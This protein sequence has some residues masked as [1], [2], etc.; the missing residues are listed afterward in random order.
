MEG[1]AVCSRFFVRRGKPAPTFTRELG[2]G[3]SC[4]FS[5]KPRGLGRCDWQERAW[6]RHLGQVPAQRVSDLS[7]WERAQGEYGLPSR[8]QSKVP[9]GCCQE[10]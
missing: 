10:G 9:G 3:A 6:C 7:G 1:G 4:G 5:L 8:G 2:G